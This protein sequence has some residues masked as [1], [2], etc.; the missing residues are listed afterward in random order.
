MDYR[1]TGG[2]RTSWASGCSRGRGSWSKCGWYKP[3]D[4]SIGKRGAGVGGGNGL[5]VEL[6]EM[7][8][9]DAVLPLNCNVSCGGDGS[10]GNCN[11]F[12]VS[13]QW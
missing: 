12:R 10:D 11:S 5:S 6:L 1:G 3:S 4:W 8:G 7:Y 9:K 13:G 2:S